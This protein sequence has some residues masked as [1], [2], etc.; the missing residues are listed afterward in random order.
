MSDRL[1]QH[2][3]ER[4]ALAITATI[5]THLGHL[6]LWLTVPLVLALLAR[7]WLRRRGAAKVSAW[8]RLPL[9]ALLLVFVITSYGNVFGRGP[10]SALACGLLA[11]KLLE[12]ERVRDAR[13]VLGFGAFVLMSALLFTQTLLFSLAVGLVL[14]L[15]LVALVAL[16]PAPLQPARSLRGEIRVAALLLGTSLPLAAAAFVLLPRF[17]SPLW[18]SPG[19]DG[20]GR[21]GLSES[22]APGQFSELMLDDS[23]AFRVEFD[24]RPPTASLLYFR[25]IVLGD[26]DGTTWTHRRSFARPD[27]TPPS[28]PPGPVFDYQITLEATDRFWLPSLDLP[29]AAPVDARLAPDQVLVSS[30]PI[31]Q[32]RQY[33]VRS[34]PQG[35][36]ATTLGKLERSRML[37]LPVGFGTKARALAARWRS[38]LRDDDRVV[39]AALSRFH[40]TFTYTLNPPLL[41]RDSVDDFLFD[42]QRGFCEH[43]ASAFVF[44]MRAAGIPARVVTGYQGG[45]WNAGAS[46]LLVRQADAHAWAEIWREGSGWQRVD[47]TAAVNSARVEL[48]AAA[49]ND[50]ANWAQAEWLRSLRN[51]LDVASRLWTE[52]I[53][54]F[55]ALRQR[56][57]FTEFGFSEVRHGDLLLALSGALAFAM[58]LAT[59]WAMRS[60][61]PR[62]GDT[63]DR[64]WSRFA[65]RLARVGIAQVPTEG[66]LDLRERMRRTAPHIAHDVDPLIDDYIDLRYGSA[67]PARERVATLA[68]RLRRIAL[69]RR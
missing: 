42:T 36:L 33:R 29:L 7:V 4:V 56:G 11:L 55:D 8:I 43:Y 19:G 13:V 51:H 23:P 64:A 38:E 57:L 46:Y 27:S 3:F 34:A 30:S 14:V 22:M 54:R 41:S 17:G 21:S 49:A 53:I 32:P 50:G 58:L 1:D 68:A 35:R 61:R 2:Q 5:A 12:T 15:L 40:A 59:L 20:Q 18:G 63:L 16:Q 24:G 52:S 60:A 39:Q 45:W 66:P 9:T 65:V 69:P 10:G 31:A 28:A 25:T 37:A 47:P 44:L 48:G 6:P 26:F 67:Y 62:S